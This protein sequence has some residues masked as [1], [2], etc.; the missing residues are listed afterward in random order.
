MGKIYTVWLQELNSGHI[1]TK[2]NYKQAK[3]A[4]RQYTK[5]S[6]Y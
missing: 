2:F 1:T 5:I 3:K 4:S 6:N